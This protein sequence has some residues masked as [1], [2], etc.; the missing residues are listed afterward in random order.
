V[1]WL[2][3]IKWF[4]GLVM[5]FIAAFAVRLISIYGFGTPV[6]VLTLFDIVAMAMIS[7]AQIA[8]CLWGL[9]QIVD[10]ERGRWVKYTQT[11]LTSV[12][13]AGG[14]FGLAYSAWP[15]SYDSTIRI[16]G[17][18]WAACWSFIVLLE[19]ARLALSWHWKPL[20]VARAVLDEAVAMKI[21]VA[22]I[23]IMLV[24]LS[25]LPFALDPDEPL[26]YRIMTFMSWSIAI[27]STKLSVLT[28]VL[29]CWTLSNEI[30]QKQIFTVAV[31]PVSRGTYLLGKW[32]G[33][34]VLDGI[35][36]AVSGIAIYGFTVFYLANLPAMD[37]VDRQA[38]HTEVLIARVTTG[39]EP[40]RP[41]EER[42]IDKLRDLIQNRPEDVL[43][44][45]KDEATRRGITWAGD[46]ELREIG[47][48][49][50]TA[51]LT[52]EA[53]NDWRAIGPQE[54]ETYIFKGLDPA[55]TLWRQR[56]D[57]WHVNASK[58]IQE[59]TGERLDL[60]KPEELNEK[61]KNVP[62]K[63]VEQLPPRPVDM[64]QFRYKMRAPGHNTLQ[65]VWRVNG[66]V[67]PIEM[68]LGDYQTIPIPVN[69]IQDGRLEV[70]IR[71][72]IRTA[73]TANFI[74][75][76]E[77]LYP[78]GGFTTN[79]L[80]AM[81][82]LWVKLAFLAM[83][84]LFAATFL[85]FPVAS[86]LGFSMWL[87]AIM[88]GYAADSM[89]AFDLGENIVAGA[90]SAGIRWINNILIT[91]L[92]KYGDYTP[93]ALVVEGKLFSWGE[94]ASCAFW[95]GI[96]WTGIVAALAWIIYQRKELA[97]VQV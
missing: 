27:T 45:G 32:I 65:T 96:V 86:L 81:L 78:V 47:K 58:K 88:S 90:L 38:I 41:L 46:A 39:P 93:R 18:F 4:G 16:V 31:K 8:W 74:E 21:V 3:W 70:Q 20:A 95:I 12:W 29:A 34:V 84:G 33:I 14:F 59:L 15:D 72:P 66:R 13:L 75:E 62:R 9:R 76:I 11:L 56:Y 25:I 63:V 19:I 24:A 71:S 89:R 2:A 42:V 97:K 52:A 50:A 23:G 35:L 1:N 85:S 7:L 37:F 53:R 61:L 80:R 49:Y 54:T 94:L 68:T 82:A 22:L 91:V 36:L 40:A 67:T 79:Y 69:F 10:G 51:L 60:S 83:L 30:S 73:P 92:G 64:L 48:E 26:R 87:F 57:K 5:L 43:K 17:V 6:D 77:I 55:F 44:M 28:I